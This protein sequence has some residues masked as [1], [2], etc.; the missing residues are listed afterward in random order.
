[1][2][3]ASATAW[4]RR[5]RAIDPRWLQ[6][7]VL[8]SL[9]C[10]ARIALEQRIPAVNALGA[11]GGA[12]LAERVCTFLWRRRFDPRSALITGLSLTLLLRTA[13]P[14]LM[15]LAALGAITGKY[16]LR[17]HGKQVFNPSNIAIVALTALTPVVWISTGQW[18]Q[19]ALLVAVIAC[20]GML[21][22][23]RAARLDLALSFC[24]IWSAALCTRAVWLGDPLAIALHQLQDGTLVIFAFFMITDPRATPDHRLG[25]FAFAA[26]L[27]AVAYY[28]RFVEFQPDA[29]LRALAFVS[30]LT[31]LLDRWQRAARF[32]WPSFAPDRS[33]DPGTG[34]AAA[35]IRN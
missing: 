35:T 30:P 11:I 4:L 29:V 27:C 8:A 24:I 1:M 34:A 22:C 31:P 6:I 23:A 20:L 10:Y 26:V 21:V 13:S 33:P 32:Q 17:V 14:A 7:A 18:G 5:L 19:A 9:L 12:V 28:L 2:M 3:R 25:R 16:V 15:L